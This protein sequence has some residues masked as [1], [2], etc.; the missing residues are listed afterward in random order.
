M[1]S[2]LLKLMSITVVLCLL[3][4]STAFALG[5]GDH[6]QE[7]S[8]NNEAGVWTSG[9]VDLTFDVTEH[10]TFEI[11][12]IETSY[13]VTPKGPDDREVST[14]FQM[15]LMVLGQSISSYNVTVKGTVSNVSSDWRITSVTF[16]RT[17]GITVFTDYSI[18]GYKATASLEIDEYNYYT[19]NI[20]LGSGGTFTVVPSPDNP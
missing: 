1:K 19:A 13:M 16:R 8:E 2:K 17:S 7:L 11:S 3:S 6:N 5:S 12:M 9:I 10:V 14:T 15:K 20:T 18:S 4:A